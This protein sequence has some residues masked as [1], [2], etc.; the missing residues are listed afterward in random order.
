M[1]V[2]LQIADRHRE[3]MWRCVFSRHT[4][5]QSYCYSWQLCVAAQCDV[6]EVTSVWQP[7]HRRCHYRVLSGLPWRWR[8]EL[9]SSWIHWYVQ[10][11]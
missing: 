8:A 11:W 7:Q 9:A 5:R 4:S 2:F 6:P 1:A 3:W 10:S